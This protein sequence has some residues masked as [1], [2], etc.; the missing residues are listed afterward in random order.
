MFQ[1]T[2]ESSY[3]HNQYLHVY[4]TQACQQPT[5]SPCSLHNLVKINPNAATI[6]TFSYYMHMLDMF[7]ENTY[8][9]NQ[10]LSYGNKLVTSLECKWMFLC[11]STLFSWVTFQLSISLSSLSVPTRLV[12]LSYLISFTLPRRAMYT[13]REAKH[14]KITLYRFSILRPLLTSNGPE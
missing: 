8:H 14:V 1:L 3:L 9:L 11:N 5:I 7:Q 4:T 10:F 6:H 13:A 12:L 2:H